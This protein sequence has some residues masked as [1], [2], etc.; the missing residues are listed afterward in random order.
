MSGYQD[1]T[2]E[3]AR[4]KN[5]Y[6]SMFQKSGK[7]LKGEP[8]YNDESFLGGLERRDFKFLAHRAISF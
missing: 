4:P 6:K 3:G 2:E 7:K 5:R 8:L 1:F